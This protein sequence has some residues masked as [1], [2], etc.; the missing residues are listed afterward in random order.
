M[1]IESVGIKNYKVIDFFVGKN[2]CRKNSL[3]EAIFLNCQSA[4]SEIFV[5]V[6]SFAIRHIKLTIGNLD[7]FF[8]ERIQT[9][10]LR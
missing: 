4:N 3:L 9:M 1:M 5:R 7:C 10:I 8:I 2:N 6:I